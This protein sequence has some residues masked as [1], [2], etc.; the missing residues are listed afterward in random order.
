VDEGELMDLILLGC[1]IFL[2]AYLFLMVAYCL[3][4]IKFFIS[5]FTRHLMEFRK[6]ARRKGR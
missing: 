5:L 3:V 2:F 1:G 4:E 6:E